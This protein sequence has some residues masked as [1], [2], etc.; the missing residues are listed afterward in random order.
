MNPE[1]R[2]EVVLGFYVERKVGAGTFGQ[3]F[4]ALDRATQRTMALKVVKYESVKDR[5][6]AD[7][8][9]RILALLE[10]R[11]VSAAVRLDRC[12]RKKDRLVMVLDYYDFDLATLVYSDS[13]LLGQRCSLLLQLCLA[14]AAVHDAGVLHRDL[15]CANVLVS[16]EGQLRIGD[17]G[18]S[19]FL[20]AETRFSS[21]YVTLQYRP[22]ELL[23]RDP[24]Y[25]FSVDIW[26]LG[27]IFVE[28]LTGRPLFHSAADE[29][30]LLQEQMQFFQQSQSFISLPS[31]PGA[32]TPTPTPSATPSLSLSDSGEGVVRR[33][34]PPTIAPLPVLC[35]PRLVSLLQEP[36]KGGPSAVELAASLLRLS[37]LDRPT[38]QAASQHQFFA[39]VSVSDSGPLTG[40]RLPNGEEAPGHYWSHR[41]YLHAQRQ[42][43]R[44][45]A[46]ER[47]ASPRRVSAN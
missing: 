13:L 34:G 46:A 31:W 30:R 27:C 7:H 42:Q 28:V 44:T 24:V 43:S 14:L 11:H 15:K 21:H 40:P 18:S 3:V 38:A 12:F 35:P 39:G 45:Q 16:K 32:V 37:P 19:T 41:R 1:D 47:D 5:S 33:S 23:K 22:P 17:F 4:K 8:E 36:E 9:L 2:T 6:W 10:A 29:P 20:A 26:S 25:G